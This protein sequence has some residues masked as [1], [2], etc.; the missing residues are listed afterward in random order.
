MKPE[1]VFVGKV[2]NPSLLP[3]VAGGL[4][5]FTVHPLR[6]G[7]LRHSKAQ[8]ISSSGMTCL[9]NVRGTGYVHPGST[10]QSSWHPGD[11]LASVDGIT[12]A[13]AQDMREI[14]QVYEED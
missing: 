11:F 14:V 13:L 5:V 6:G 8:L 9:V 4:V 1:N 2:S 3:I 7:G 12:L 10:P